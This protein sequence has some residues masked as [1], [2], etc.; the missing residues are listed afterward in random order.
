[1]PEPVGS[2]IAVVEDDCVDDLRPLTD[3]RAAHRVLA[4][5][6]RVWDRLVATWQCEPRVIATRAAVAAREADITDILV[7]SNVEGLVAAAE[8]AGAP[9]VVLVLSRAVVAPASVHLLSTRGEAALWS[10][11]QPLAQQSATED[12]RAHPENRAGAQQCPDRGLHVI[13]DDA[14]EFGQAATHAPIVDRHET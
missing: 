3:V 8:A 2:F 13:A 7:V 4:G 6:F 11:D 10:G 12:I 14:A 1:M 5:A 9:E